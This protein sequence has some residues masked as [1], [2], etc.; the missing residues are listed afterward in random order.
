MP[1]VFKIGGYVIYFWINE[2]TPLE[3]VHVHVAL[4]TPVKNAT[5]I[6]ITSDGHCKLCNNNSHIPEHVLRNLMDIIEL[7]SIY[8]TVLWQMK[9]NTISFIQ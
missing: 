9:F 1:R 8:I 3:P 6:W 2:G 7:R 5:K 4:G